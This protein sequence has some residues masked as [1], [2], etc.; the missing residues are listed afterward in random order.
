MTKLRAVSAP[1]LCAFGS[2]LG[3]AACLGAPFPKQEP[4]EL[5]LEAGPSPSDFSSESTLEAR[6]DSEILAPYLAGEEGK[7]TG[8]DGAKIYYRVF[9]HP[10]EKGAIVFL[11]GRTEPILKHAENII[12]LLKQG[13]SV[14][15]MD[16]RGQGQSEGRL[17][18]SNPQIG[19]VRLFQQYA[20]DL[21]TFVSQVVHPA[22]H[23]HLF[24]LAHSMGGG[25]SALYIE[26]HPT[27]FEAVALSSPMLEI[28][29]GG[30]L[31]KT[32]ASE[33]PTL[34][35]GVGD[36]KGYGLLQHDFDP[37][38]RFEDAGND[39]TRSR[40]RYDLKMRM[41]AEHLELRLGGPSN[42]WLC[43]TFEA[44][45]HLKLLG[46]ESQTPTLLLEAGS[47]QVVMTGAEDR[48]CNDASRCQK[49]T[50]PDAQHEILG[51]RDSIRNDALA[52]TVR[53]FNHFS[54]SS[55]PSI[56]KAS[57]K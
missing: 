29:Y 4:I 15:A 26:E 6:Y 27:V 35:C 46:V 36:G 43:E 56:S 8:A 34:F 49:I 17:T 3:L 37:G 41:F 21:D 50:Y 24:L 14:Y 47:D 30:F 22:Q 18:D 40:A 45:S 42:R 11:P 7:F 19:Y 32:A 44:G 12:D 33:L 23:P 55:V 57:G 16:H 54:T 13:Y 38:I 2:A 1:I 28:N 10:N 20:D 53:F 51:E 48:Y 39:V 25:V 5:A 9:K 52:N 31:L